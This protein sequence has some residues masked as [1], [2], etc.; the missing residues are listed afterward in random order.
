MN[1][2]H[3]YNQAIDICF[4]FLENKTKVLLGIIFLFTITIVTYQFLLP[5]FLILLFL[6]LDTLIEMYRLYVPMIP[7]DL[8]LLTFATIYLTV[9]QGT[10][11]AIIF[12]LFSL[13]AMTISR[14]HFHPSFIIKI[15]AL[16]LLSIIISITGFSTIK[17]II[18][19]IIVV[20]LQFTGYFFLMS[21]DPVK[22]T[23]SRITNILFNYF[24][25][26]SFGFLIL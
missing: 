15:L 11:L 1:F 13:I 22:S 25:L 2:I 20:V 24:L 4:D 23:I 3:T 6:I 9:T 21:G 17:A 5:V 12:I 19:I 14:G 18:A 16:I 26:T 7:I 10:G 8:E